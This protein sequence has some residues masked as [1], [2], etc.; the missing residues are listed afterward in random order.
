MLAS[1]GLPGP[2]ENCVSIQQRLRQLTDET[3][4]DFTAQLL[5]DFQELAPSSLAELREAL[6]GGDIFRAGR[7]AHSIKSNCATFG[8]ANLARRLLEVELACRAGRMVQA[9]AVG[10][11]ERDY[12]AAAD[13]LNEVMRNLIEGTV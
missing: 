13:E 8:L 11:L 10:D 7:I 4:L 1:A 12:R 3:D 2:V 5:G 6:A 9:Q